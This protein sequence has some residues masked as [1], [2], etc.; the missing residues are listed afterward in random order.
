MVGYGTSLQTISKKKI[1]LEFEFC[2]LSSILIWI[3]ISLFTHFFFS[4]NFFHNGIILALDLILFLIKIK[5]NINLLKSYLNFI[6]I[7]FGILI[8]GLLI[9]KSHDDF[10]YYHSDAQKV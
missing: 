4:H 8:L 9:S 3:V 7:I 1:D 5:K 6:L 2:L 10:S